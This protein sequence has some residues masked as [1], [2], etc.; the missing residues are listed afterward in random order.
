MADGVRAHRPLTKVEWTSSEAYP[1]F[2]MWRKE[3][4]RIINGPMAAD[5]DA[6]KLNTVY[7]W[8]GA[9]A[10]TL[11]EAGMAEDPTLKIEKA[12][13]LLDC[14]NTC[15]THSTFFLEARGDFYNVK[16][17]PGEN[18]STFYS[19]IMELYRLADFPE[20]SDFLIVDRLIHCC[21]NVDCKRNLM[22]KGKDATV[23]T[24]LDL[25]RHHEAVDITMKHLG[26]AC[27]VN[28]TYTRDPT[29]QSLKNGSRTK[30]K[31]K[32]KPSASSTGTTT[33]AKRPQAA[34]KQCQWCGS[35]QH[36]REKLSS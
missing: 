13:D 32:P 28:A 6:V 30:Q 1:Q 4:E 5:K 27:K 14:L 26:E 16:Q 31:P 12:A 9:H 35:D 36:S 21:I 23:K 22:T 34:A 3:V 7:I 18:T 24:C 17:K 15:L 8:A 2:R 29:K 19:R 25:L 20:N 10:E 11:V 33:A